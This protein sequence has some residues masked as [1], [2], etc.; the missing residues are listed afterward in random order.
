M[1]AVSISRTTLPSLKLEL[2]E[3][4]GM[5]DR[6]LGQGDEGGRF[7]VLKDGALVRNPTALRLLGL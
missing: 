2:A 7:R 3:L 1:L 6:S 4:K 5:E